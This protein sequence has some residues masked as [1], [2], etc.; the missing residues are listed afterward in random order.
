LTFPLLLNDTIRPIIQK[1]DSLD[2]Q[3]DKFSTYDILFIEDDFLIRK[4]Y[5]EVLKSYFANV[6]EASNGE[7]AYTIYLK[8]KPNIL[9]VDLNIPK[10]S[11]L[12]LLEKIRS[13]DLNTKVILFTSHCDK[14]TLLK[15]SILKLTQYLIKPVGRKDLIN[16]LML[17][18]EEI[19]NFNIFSKKIVELKD[20][21]YWNIDKSELYCKNDLIKITK[22]EKDILKIIFTNAVNNTITTYDQLLYSIWDENSESSLKSLKTFMTTIR[23]K[24]PKDTILNEYSMGYKVK[25]N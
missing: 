24:L 10:I 25:F 1:G 9:I 17:A 4:N 2:I 13:S 19:E 14:E 5:T 6:Y 12:E 8:K 3:Y 20:S 16:A 7:E 21:F 22:K 11:G 18:V 23:K 15:A